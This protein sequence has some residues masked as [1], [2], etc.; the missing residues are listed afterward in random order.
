MSNNLF[1][2]ERARPEEAAA[3]ALMDAITKNWISEEQIQQMTDRALGRPVVIKNIKK[4]SGGFF[5]RNSRRKNGIK[6]GFRS[7]DQGYAP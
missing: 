7:R 3:S 5:S 2:I 1:V 4:L 6:A